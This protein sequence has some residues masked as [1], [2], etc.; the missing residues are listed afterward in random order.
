MERSEH[1][2]QPDAVDIGPQEGRIRRFLRGFYSTRDAWKRDPLWGTVFFIAV[3]ALALAINEGI[4]YAKDKVQGPD[5]Y[6]VQ[7]AEGQQRE[8][9]TLKASLGQISSSLA[10]GDRAAVREATA[11]LQSL[12]ST[13][14]GLVQQLAMA[15]RENDKLREISEQRAGIAGGYDIILSE[16]GG[17]RLDAANVLGVEAIQSN[18]AVRVNLTSSAQEQP[19]QRV[20]R[21]GE[22]LAYQSASG[23]PCRVS[24]LSANGAG[25]GAAS[26]AVVCG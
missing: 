19:M 6:L 14:E 13:S 21:S 17:L 4:Q 18:G 2:P 11:T 5:A 3:G 16:N 7:I 24:L 8:F 12:Q 22:S 20:L 26:F 15:K 1:P 25:Q 23:T 10:G 9:A